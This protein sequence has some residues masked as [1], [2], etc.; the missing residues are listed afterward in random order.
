[1]GLSQAQRRQRERH[2][3]EIRDVLDTADRDLDR[4]TIADQTSCSRTTVMRAIRDM[5]D[6]VPTREIGNIT[7]YE[8]TQSE[9]D[10]NGDG[11][12]DTG[13]D[14]EHLYDADAY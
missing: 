14:N 7:L 13:S 10:E 6:I 5:D 9:D 2:R 3:R 4:Q 12:A 1:M 11:G 8:R